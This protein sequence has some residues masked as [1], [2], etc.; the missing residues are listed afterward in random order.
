MTE[1]R[2]GRRP[3]WPI[4]SVVAL[5]AL[6]ALGLL[7][8]AV[9]MLVPGFADPV[10]L[11]LVLGV[12]VLAATALGLWQGRRGGR[13]AGLVL[14]AAWLLTGLTAIGRGDGSGSLYAVLGVVVIGALSLRPARAWTT[15]RRPELS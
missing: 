8:S 1:G 2:R 4:V 5:F 7:G 6:V 14:G 15:G 9:V 10:A 13:V 12:V 11:V 3:P